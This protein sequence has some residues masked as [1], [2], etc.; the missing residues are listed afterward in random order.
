MLSVQNQD[1]RTRTEP[2]SEM[3]TKRQKGGI[4]IKEIKFGKTICPLMTQD[5]HTKILCDPECALL[6]T[7]VTGSTNSTDKQVSYCGL[8]AKSL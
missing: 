1:S 4:T 7:V 6:H 3:S 2:L 8:I 5:G